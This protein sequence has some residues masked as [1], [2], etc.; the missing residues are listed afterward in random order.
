MALFYFSWNERNV[1]NQI[2]KQRNDEIYMSDKSDR[3]T[4]TKS[5]L[6]LHCPAK[7]NLI[8]NVVGARN[9]PRPFTT[10][11]EQTPGS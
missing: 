6:F 7:G 9:A 5:L 4:E 10:I 1:M 3:K 8:L 11:D 2:K